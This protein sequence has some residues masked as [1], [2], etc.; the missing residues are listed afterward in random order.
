[1]RMRACLTYGVAV[2]A[3]IVMAASTGVAQDLPSPT[4]S[5]AGGG[6]LER[7]KGRVVSRIP[8]NVRDNDPNTRARIVR[9]LPPG[10]AVEIACVDQGEK[11]FGVADWYLLYTDYTHR[12]FVSAR[13]VKVDAG[14]KPITC[15][16]AYARGLD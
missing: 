9:S 8:L 16:E 13:Y 14:N 10:T 4:P 6:T 3:A 5:P 12:A 1:M 15:A 11:I 2:T 7:W